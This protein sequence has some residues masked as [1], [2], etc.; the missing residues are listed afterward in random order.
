MSTRDAMHGASRRPW[1]PR[2]G[3]RS[4]GDLVPTEL[5]RPSPYAGETEE[6]WWVRIVGWVPKERRA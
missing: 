6:Q 3:E 5:I 1:P 4:R 2:P